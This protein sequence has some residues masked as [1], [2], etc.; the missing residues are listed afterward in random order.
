MRG[1]ESWTCC[2]VVALLEDTAVLLRPSPKQDPSAPLHR[3]HTH[4][5]YNLFDQ[6]KLFFSYITIIL[7]NIAECRRVLESSTL[8]VKQSQLLRQNIRQMLTSAISR[9]KAAHCIVNDGLVKKIAE[10]VGLQVD[11][12]QHVAHLSA[13]NNNSLRSF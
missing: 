2:L 12:M 10:T 3:V 9:Q 1:L 13:P 8:T 4:T 5:R 7:L 11:Q 6:H